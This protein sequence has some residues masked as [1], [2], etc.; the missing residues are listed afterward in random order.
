MKLIHLLSRFL[1]APA[2]GRGSLPITTKFVLVEADPP[3]KPGAA[4]ATGRV[5]DSC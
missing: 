4:N 1:A 2:S 3:A 5:D